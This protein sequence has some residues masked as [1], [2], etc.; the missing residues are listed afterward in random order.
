MIRTG[1]TPG[2]ARVAAVEVLHVAPG[3]TIDF[4]PDLLAY[5]VP[6][7]QAPAG[8]Y[9]FMALLDTDHSYA[10]N[11]MGP[12]DLYGPVVTVTELNPA[13]A[14]P[15]ELVLNQRVAPRRPPQDTEN[16][17]L[18]EFRSALLS[19]FWGR[20]ITMRAGVVLPPSYA[21]VPERRYPTVYSIHGFGGD[22]RS[23]WSAGPA[24]VR[25]M[26]DG[27]R[28]EIVHVYLD[29]SFSTGHV[30]FADSVNNGPWGRA[31]VEELVPQLEKRFR[32]VAQPHGR[33]LTGHS[34][35]GWSSL[36]LQ[37]SHPD[38]FGG[39]WST[40]PDPVDFRSYTGVDV[41]ILSKENAYR[42]E[43]GQPRGMVRRGTQY[44]AT[45]EQFAKQEMVLGEFG[46][47]LASF[48][49]VF[50]PRGPDGRPMP[51]FNR[52]TGALYPEVQAAWEK[53]DIRLVLE[54]NWPTLGPKLKGKLHLFCGDQDTFRLNEA[55]KLLGESLK[56]LG[57][58][59]VVE[60]I[61]GRN[62][63]DLYRSF[64]SYPEGLDMRIDREMKAAFEAGELQPRASAPF[65]ANPQAHLWRG[66]GSQM[67]DAVLA[68]AAEW[69]NHWNLY[70]PGIATGGTGYGP[71][72]YFSGPRRVADFMALSHVTALPL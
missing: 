48:E 52:Q 45:F 40:S 39:T 6:L 65:L 72:S 5:P 12:D 34:S 10:R 27:Q 38:F 41:S 57:S 43:K 33:F 58:D 21:K 70:F 31:L 14:K 66:R 36:W 37:I 30:A 16:V 26:A 53:Y 49:W 50:S 13:D 17:K 18:V 55:F 69:K 54:R 2:A 44:V 4:D 7:S 23:A 67:L 25:Q 3:Q 11:G 59:A 9:H 61:P 20:P 22:H 8:T 47:Q 51:L 19:E 71:S 29:A 56:A 15:V 63:S 60:M 46:G 62:H 28:A 35:G 24:L 42:D 32:L 1:F 64:T 68:A